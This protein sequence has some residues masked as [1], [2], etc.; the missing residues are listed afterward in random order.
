MYKKNIISNILCMVKVSKVGK[1]GMVKI[2]KYI[3]V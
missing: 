2:S 3:S 1:L